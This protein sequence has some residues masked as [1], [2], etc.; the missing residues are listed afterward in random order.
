MAKNSTG[1]VIACGWSPRNRSA[2]PA[3]LQPRSHGEHVY[4]VALSGVL[5]HNTYA[6]NVPGRPGGLGYPGSMA[7][8]AVSAAPSI[9]P[10]TFGLKTIAEDAATLRMWND[11]MRSAA[12]AK[13][14]N[15]YSRYLQAIDRGDT[16]SHEMLEEAFFR[17]E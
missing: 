7:N 15:G 12:S 16:I 2:A 3:R 11:A 9:T 4:R 10:A 6:E 17:S 1:W 14:A 8:A 5:V 13:R